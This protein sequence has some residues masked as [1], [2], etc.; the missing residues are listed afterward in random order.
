MPKQEACFMHLQ[1][2]HDKTYVH[3]NAFPH[4]PLPGWLKALLGRQPQQT[5]QRSVPPC[6]YSGEGVDRDNL[7]MQCGRPNYA[8][9]S[10]AQRLLLQRLLVTSSVRN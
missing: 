7:T 2:E 9:V 3:N 10:Q 4:V 1:T 6:S 5:D 8:L